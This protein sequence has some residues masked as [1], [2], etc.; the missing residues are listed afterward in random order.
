M[1]RLIFFSLSLFFFS[2]CSNT[3]DELTKNQEAKLLDEMFS[4]IENLALSQECDD[5]TEWRITSYGSK[6]CGGPIGY[7]AYSINIDTVSFLNKI[8]KHRIAQQAFNEKWDIISDC[9]VPIQPE[10]VIC[11][12]SKPI[13]E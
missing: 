10:S 11:V 3:D 6:A 12:D 8:E 1:F 4:E 2:A 9:S 5:P 13:L 7:L